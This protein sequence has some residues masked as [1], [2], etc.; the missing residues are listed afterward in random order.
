MTNFR[1]SRTIVENPL[2]WGNQRTP[3]WKV[4]GADLFRMCQ[5]HSSEGNFY[6]RHWLAVLLPNI[7]GNFCPRNR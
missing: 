6:S 2:A 1:S 5:M 4:L 3:D 7:C